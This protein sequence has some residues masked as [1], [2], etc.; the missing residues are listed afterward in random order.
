MTDEV[1]M[2]EE[3]AEQ[4]QREVAANWCWHRNQIYQRMRDLDVI[5]Q[6]VEVAMWP[7]VSDKV[8]KIMLRARSLISAAQKAWRWDD[9]PRAEILLDQVNGAHAELRSSIMQSSGLHHVERY[10]QLETVE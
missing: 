7:L 9:F 10:F 5:E 2:N 8:S 3:E 4:L 6:Q 1:D